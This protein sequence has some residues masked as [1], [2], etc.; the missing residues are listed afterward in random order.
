MAP[1]LRKRKLDG[2]AY[3]RPEPVEKMLGELEFLP[4]DVMLERCRVRDRGDPAYVSTECVMHLIRASHRDNSQARFAKL[5]GILLER[6]AHC[7]PRSRNT[8]HISSTQA[9]INELVMDTLN[10]LVSSDRNEY[11]EKLDYFE[12]R[13]DGA[14]AKLRLDAQRKVWRKQ[15]RNS[16][17]ENPETGELRP[18]VEQALG[19]YD[20]FEDGK[21]VDRDYR[22]KLDA[23]I[24][25]LPL[26]QQ[27]I[28]HMLRKGI[29]IDSQD[30]YAVTISKTLGK[31]E[32]T[33]R[34][35]RKKAYAT[36]R[37][38]LDGDRS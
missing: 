34:S 1:P 14:M 24:D 35:N 10:L 2:S 21:I 16:Q 3:F 4:R 23:A 29:P 31:V 8:V 27:R 7:L 15:N 6:A 30:T 36:L 12:I 13:F 33:I 38:I 9:E 22:S 11:C 19:R 37:C 18:E 32:K 26:L 25:T 5:Y 17:I 20:P 28:V